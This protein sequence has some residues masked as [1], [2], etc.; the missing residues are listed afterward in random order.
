MRTRFIRAGAVVLLAVASVAVATPATAA[1][2]CDVPN[3]P[4]ICDPVDDYG[5]PTVTLGTPVRQPAGLSVSGTAKDPDGSGPVQVQIKIQ[6][7]VVGTLSANRSTGAYSGIVPARAGSTVCAVALNQNEGQNTSTCRTFAVSVDPIGSVD[8]VSPGPAGLR[9]RGWSID[10]DTANP[11]DVHVYLDGAYARTVNAAGSRAD[12]AAVY[13]AYGAAHGYDLTLPAGP[14][15]HTVC[16]Y[17]INVGAGTVNT[18]LGC[19]TVTQGSPPAAPD[20]QVNASQ[21]VPT[22]YLYVQPRSTN[23]SGFVIERSTGGSAGPWTQ[24][25]SN[26]RTGDT[27]FSWDDTGV[28]QGQQYCYRVRAD[29]AYGSATSA[30]VCRDLP[31]PAL[32]RPTNVSVTGVTETSLVLNWF[33]NAVGETQYRVDH[34]GVNTMYAPGTAGTGPMTFAMNNLQPATRYCFKIGPIKSGFGFDPAPEI[35]ATTASPPPPPPVSVKTVNIWNCVS[36]GVSGSVWLFDHGTASWSRAASAPSSWVGRSCGTPYSGPS[37]SVNLPDGRVVTV[38]LVIA[39]N[40]FCTT[41]DPTS[42]GCRRWEAGPVLGGV[43]GI[44]TYDVVG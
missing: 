6:G 4:P 31:L 9:V 23:A 36:A 28:A 34:V 43:K 14:G 12:V 5:N 19:G 10:P 2:K 26:N 39:G 33:D 35:C 16:V 42:T 30:V 24:V 8:E 7:V 27:A 32:P 15:A 37:A 22:I 20:I 18:Q 38:A 21:T 3:P 13:P 17:G 11:I 29:N 44:T 41:E 1:P 40:K 25:H